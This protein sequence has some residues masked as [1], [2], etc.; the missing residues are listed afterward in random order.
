MCKVFERFLMILLGSFAITGMIFLSC[1]AFPSTLSELKVNIW[2]KV[3]TDELNPGEIIALDMSKGYSAC[4][5]PIV[6]IVVRVVDSEEEVV[7]AFP[8]GGYWSAPEA[9]P[10]LQELQREFDN[11][12]EYLK[13]GDA[14][15]WK[16]E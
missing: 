14:T 6:Y 7:I 11:L 9:D 15:E 5:G 13:Q 2:N 4:D 12:E 1:S 8:N 16:K 10:F 3:S